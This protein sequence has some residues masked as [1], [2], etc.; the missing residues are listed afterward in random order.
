MHWKRDIS[1]LA[2]IAEGLCAS[3]ITCLICLKFALSK[4]ISA[5]VIKKNIYF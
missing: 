2:Q 4:Y 1:I 3:P 5:F